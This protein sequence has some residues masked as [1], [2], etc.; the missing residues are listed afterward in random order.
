MI[1]T[2]NKNV[3][4]L[5]LFLIGVFLLIILSILKGRPGGNDWI[6]LFFLFLAIKYI[7]GIL[8]YKITIVENRQI[9]AF[10]TSFGNKILTREDVREWGLRYDVQHTPQGPTS[11]VNL[12]VVTYIGTFKY[13]VKYWTYYLLSDV[14]ENLIAKAWNQSPKK[15]Q[16]NKSPIWISDI[17]ALFASLSFLWL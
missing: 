2:V 5:L 9:V 11:Y 15:Y 13:P 17:K 3:K 6:L 7:E 1:S 14:Q 8:V 16:D 4:L 12:E 10:R